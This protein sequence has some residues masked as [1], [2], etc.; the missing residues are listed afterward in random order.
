MK[1]MR[2]LTVEG[3]ANQLT[4]NQYARRCIESTL[5]NDETSTDAEI[6]EYFMMEIGLSEAE[7]RA[8]VAKRDEYL[9]AI[10]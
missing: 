3:L 2:K 6:I 8:W 1:T 5:S 7:A 4:E 10:L 9:R